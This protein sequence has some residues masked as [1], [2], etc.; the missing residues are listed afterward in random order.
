[1]KLIETI[2]GKW[3]TAYIFKDKNRDHW[4]IKTE[5]E[6]F[7]LH[8]MYSFEEAKINALNYVGGYREEKRKELK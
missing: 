4:Y 1:M 2:K 8:R 7:I 6:G 5:Y 3:D